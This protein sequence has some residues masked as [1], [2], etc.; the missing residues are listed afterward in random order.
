MI[1]PFDHRRRR[2]V[3]D[4]DEPAARMRRAGRRN[5]GSP[6]G[7]K[8]ERDNR[9]AAVALA[10]PRSGAGGQPLGKRRR[11][12][13]RFDQG[14]AQFIAIRIA[15]DLREARECRGVGAGRRRKFAYRSNCRIEIVGVHV[16]SGVLQLRRQRRQRPTARRAGRLTG[17]GSCNEC[18][19]SVLRM[20]QMK[21]LKRRRADR[22]AAGERPGGRRQPGR[23]SFRDKKTAQGVKAPRA[24]GERL[25]GRHQ[26]PAD[27]ELIMS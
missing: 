18:C 25:A 6:A 20:Q 27:H 3:G 5:A 8:A 19:I 14:A 26:P 11:R 1:G 24:A 9:I 7:R 12:T 16:T 23:A 22:V 13:A 2:R 17:G 15:E 4:C 10:P 21:Y